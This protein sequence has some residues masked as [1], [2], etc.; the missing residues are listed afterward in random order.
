MSKADGSW[1]ME[2][3]LLSG[4]VAIVAS[5]TGGEYDS[6]LMNIQNI[7][8]QGLRSQSNTT[9]PLNTVEERGYL[10][11]DPMVCAAAVSASLTCAEALNGKDRY[12]DIVET[13]ISS[14]PIIKIQALQA[15]IRT[16][17]LPFS[18]VSSCLP[19]QYLR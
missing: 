3:A 7:S 6:A 8:E 11:V 10:M 13:I 17:T 12:V 14:V 15:I 18:F 16:Y 19:V 9:A 4:V 1:R 5:G 2:E